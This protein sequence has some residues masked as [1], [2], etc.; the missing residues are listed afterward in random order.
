M[1]T[2]HKEM[3]ECLCIEADKLK[4]RHFW[5]QYL[6]NSEFAHIYSYMWVLRHLEYYGYLRAKHHILMAVPYLTMLLLHRQLR[7]KLGI[8][9]GPNVAGVG[10]HIMNLGFVRAYGIAKFGKNCT[11]S[12]MVLFGKKTP[13][14]EGGG[15]E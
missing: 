12:P 6:S 1:F 2:S 5:A 7:I 9:I 13:D 8:H 10:F 11:V 3:K 14:V 4:I 15:G